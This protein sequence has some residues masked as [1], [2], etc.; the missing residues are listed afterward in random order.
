MKNWGV[1]VDISIIKRLISILKENNEMGIENMPQVVMNIKQRR[2]VPQNITK[3][4][5]PGTLNVPVFDNQVVSI[6]LCKD[7]QMPTHEELDEG[8][9]VYSRGTGG[10][11]PHYS[12]NID[13]FSYVLFFPGG[14]QSF[15]KDK[16]PK[17]TEVT[18]KKETRKSS[19]KV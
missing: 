14:E 7:G 4:I 15:V 19:N 2:D 11:I 5:Y 9:V 6:F 16:L 12:Y 3:N 18:K 10:T 13:A 1:K 8:I 17:S